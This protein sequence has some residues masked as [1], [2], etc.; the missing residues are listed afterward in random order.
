MELELVK[1]I[2]RRWASRPLLLCAWLCLCAVPWILAVLGPLGPDAR[3]LFSSRMIYEVAFVWGLIG[4]LIGL[5]VLG[6][7]AAGLEPLGAGRRLRAHAVVLGSCI[8]VPGLPIVA[9]GFLPAAG[10]GRGA[11]LAGFLWMAAHLVAIG[12]I[13]GQIQPGP[14]R[15][16]AFLSLAWWF[17]ALVSGPLRVMVVPVFDAT[18]HLDATGHL[19]ASSGSS[20]WPA[21]CAPILA[22][23]LTA[24]GVDLVRRPA[25]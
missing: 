5:T 10:E 3:S 16:I 12:M 6:E 20:A 7:I 23:V 13:A 22:L 21:A 4:G 14:L 19:E 24:I 1:L 15:S 25:S 18:R 17:P 11:G 2:G 8:L 9:L